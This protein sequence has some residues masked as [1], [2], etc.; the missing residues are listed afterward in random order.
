VDTS[1][2]DSDTK[3]ITDKDLTTNKVGGSGKETRKSHKQKEDS[4]ATKSSGKRKKERHSGPMAKKRK[5]DSDDTSSLVV[6]VSDGDEDSMDAM[7]T[8]MRTGT[9]SKV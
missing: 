6:P 8:R 4:S 1:I 5:T 2:T 3:E 7:Q 9:I